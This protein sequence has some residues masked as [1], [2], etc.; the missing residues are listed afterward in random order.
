[1]TDI[2]TS[3]EQRNPYEKKLRDWENDI[4]E[5]ESFVLR[6]R[7]VNLINVG[8]SLLHKRNSPDED[9]LSEKRNKLN[10]IQSGIRK[11]T[12]TLSQTMS[13]DLSNPHL[14]NYLKRIVDLRLKINHLS[15]KLEQKD[16]QDYIKSII[17]ED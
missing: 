4:K 9:K 10:K 11:M 7:D 5:I 13:D 16:P 12:E 8:L 6:V 14:D 17:N 1:M 15:K 2:T 3:K